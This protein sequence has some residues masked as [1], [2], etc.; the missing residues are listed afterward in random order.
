M[1]QCI[2]QDESVRCKHTFISF[3]YKQETEAYQHIDLGGTYHTKDASV[4][5][6]LS[7][8]PTYLAVL[9]MYCFIKYNKG[10]QN[11]STERLIILE[12]K[13]AVLY[14]AALYD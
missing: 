7:L 3:G 4:G 5:D 2:L 6:G 11:A 13:I 10:K 14:L 12:V 9:S 1:C 8:Y